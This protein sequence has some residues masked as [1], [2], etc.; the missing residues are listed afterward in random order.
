MLFVVIVCWLSMLFVIVV[1]CLLFVIVVRCFV[2][3]KRPL[4]CFFVIGIVVIITMTTTSKGQI[5][6]NN[7]TVTF[8]DI[9][10]GIAA[11]HM[12]LSEICLAACPHQKQKLR[13]LYSHLQLQIC[14]KH[15]LFFAVIARLLFNRTGVC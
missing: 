7:I 4:V 5:C 3:I 15:L 2:V 8:P 12:F 1:C 13:Y 10:S 6:L 11:A 9:A 14:L